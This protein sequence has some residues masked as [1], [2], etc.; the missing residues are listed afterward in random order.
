MLKIA[1]VTGLAGS[2]IML[3]AALAA[4]TEADLTPAPTNAPSVTDAP[5][6]EVASPGEAGPAVEGAASGSA[7]LSSGESAAGDA[8]DLTGLATAAGVA[9]VC[10]AGADFAAC[11]GP[12]TVRGEA[13]SGSFAMSA[14]LFPNPTAMLMD[15]TNQIG[16]RPEV[17]IPETGQIFGAFTEPMFPGPA[18]VQFNLPIVPSGGSIDLDNDGTDDR[19]IQ[20]YALSVASNLISGPY[21]E[22]LEQVSGLASYIT[23]IATGDIV[24][25][26]FLVYAPDDQQAFP[27]GRGADGKWFSTD[28][29]VIPLPAG[30]TVATLNA[31]GTVTL[32]RSSQAT[33]NSLER[34]EAK[35]L[36]FSD[37]TILESYNS[38]ID[39]L[40]I[41]YAYTELREL[42]WEAIRAEYLPRIEAADA[43]QDFGAYYVTLRELAQSIHDGH[44]AV[45]TNDA[46]A[47]LADFRSY[48]ERT[49][50]K[51]GASTFA[52]VDETT[53]LASI[54]DRLM[55]LTVAEN[56]P[57]AEAGW[58]P[59]TEIISI[60][61]QPV[62]EYLETLPSLSNFG[63][64][65]SRRA[66]LAR[67]A[68]S[69][70]NGTTVT[71]EYRQPG[72]SDVLTSVMVAGEYDTG[73]R[74]PAIGAQIPITYE[75]RGNYAVIRWPNFTDN[76][77]PKIAVLEEALGTERNVQSG[78]IVLDLRG[79]SGG[80]AQLYESMVSYFYT[81]DAPMKL[82]V[83]DWYYYDEAA[84]GHI[85]RSSPDFMLSAP[86]PELA[87]TGPVVILVD[88]NCKSACEY[89]SQHMQV[90][91]RAT[92]V[93][94]YPSEGAGGF[95]DRVQMPDQVTFQ[96][97]QGGTYFAGTD[98]PNLEAKGVMP[99][100]QVP[101]TLETEQAKLR[102]EDP[103]LDAALAF[104]DQQAAEPAP[105]QTLP[106]AAWQ[107]AAYL[108][109]VTSP[110]EVVESPEKYV[111]AFGE[112]GTVAVTADCN[113]AGGSYTPGEGSLLT[114]SL[115]LTTLASCPE[116]SHSEQFLTY[117][118]GTTS[119]AFQDGQLILSL[120]SA[121]GAV[122]IVMAPAQP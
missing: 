115:G 2:I 32:D 117:L 107:W 104:L 121:S 29:P 79:N 86:R 76:L 53:P 122:A 26:T 30:Y 100:V 55:V 66:T 58:V 75:Q 17:F 105:V 92:I 94:Q 25:G 120:D 63:T 93:G 111:I 52:V 103:V 69:F 62:A 85:L 74:E 84:Q 119:Y 108:T 40:K 99:D 18:K 71:V 110:V 95:I 56:T 4:C 14:D 59:G 68:L 27:A 22:Q 21:L 118:A 87:Y 38:L 45:A 19:G 83:F 35:S 28:D 72:S 49:F 89:F 98:E 80:L 12:I 15:I 34:A 6:G 11:G 116:G 91:D 46:D 96:F 97:T 57:A 33:M 113:Q 51:L 20:V 47:A 43:N 70:P 109:G 3:L 78:G 7:A 81:A 36:D 8:S 39:L 61:G 5:S 42:D 16:G 54:G 114:I 102:G 23:D 112:D 13:S 31:D 44:V 82:H 41:R 10:D 24:Q 106:G 101:V 50:G 1:K 77:L 9:L 60:N 90:L 88:E 73:Y 48:A 64:D 67:S 65:V 37:Q